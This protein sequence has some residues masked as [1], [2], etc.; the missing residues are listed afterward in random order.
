MYQVSS[1]GSKT[2]F[3]TFDHLKKKVFGELQNAYES[4]WEK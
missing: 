1:D 2:N 3:G 4:Y